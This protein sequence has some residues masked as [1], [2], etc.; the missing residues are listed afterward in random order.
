MEN[1]KESK[2]EIEDE[3]EFEKAFKSHFTPNKNI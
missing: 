3:E 1:F 2:F